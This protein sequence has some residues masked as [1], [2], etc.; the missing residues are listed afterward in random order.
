M[1]RLSKIAIILCVI[2]VIASVSYGITITVQMKP[3]ASLADPRF[4][5]GRLWWKPILEP[6]FR[7]S[8]PYMTTIP[9]KKDNYASPYIQKRGQ[10]K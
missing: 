3:L 7:W 4:W 10:G 1:A 2:T 6:L 9:A 8:R 5:K